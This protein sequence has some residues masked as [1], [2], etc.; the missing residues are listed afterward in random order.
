MKDREGEGEGDGDGGDR[1]ESREGYRGGLPLHHP[2]S[3]LAVT[4]KTR[5]LGS[6]KSWRFLLYLTG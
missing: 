1:G 4:A 3:W 6:G 5:Q 2:Y